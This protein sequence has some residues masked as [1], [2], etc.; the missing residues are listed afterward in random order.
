MKE[1]N[2]RVENLRKI[3]KQKGFD[4]YYVSG[5]DPHQSEYVAPRWRTRHFISGFSGSA[6]TVLVTND[7]A[8]LWT[9]SRYFIQA[10]NEIKDTCF[11]MLRQDTEDPDMISWIKSNLKKDAKIAVEASEISIASFDELNSKLEGSASFVP[12]EGFLDEIWTDRP[13]VPETSV[14][15]MKLEYAGKTSEDKIASVRKSL[16]EKGCFWTFIASLDDIAWITNLR[17]D[18][19]MYNPVF[20]SYMF[21]SMDRAILF[22]S[23]KRFEG[24]DTSSLPFEIM[25]YADAGNLLSSLAEKKGYYNPER[26]VMSFERAAK[27]NPCSSGPDITTLM[28]AKKNALEME[29]MRRAHFEDAVAF[30]NFLAKLD[31]MKKT[32]E[33]EI[34]EKLENER[35]R[36]PL[37]L[38]PSFST[39]AGFKENGAMCHYRAMKDNYKTIEGN[40]LLVLDSGGQYECGT[41]DITRTLLFGQAEENEKRDYT[42][43]LKGHLALAFQRF[44]KGTRGVQLDILAKQFLWQSGQTFYHGTGHGV[45]CRLNVHEGPMRISSALIDVPLEEG[46]VI[47]DEPGLYK[48][49]RY[50]IR[51]ENLIAVKDDVETEFGKFLSF[52]VLTMVPYE[53]RLID[54]RYLSDVEINAINSYHEWV[55]ETLKDHVDESSVPYLESATSPIVRK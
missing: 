36:R 45:G 38:G 12:V 11:K 39:I 7:D 48:E 20:Y 55:Y 37:Y 42:L 34:E 32:D 21:I 14:T 40:G 50:G 29:G 43:V 28:K 5:S 33:L 10:A 9:D 30:V 16:E 19:I 13:D 52:E 3:L 31:P 35:K 23:K 17:A 26:I 8:V 6:G 2:Q 15:Q 25:D 18:D 24:F 27:K 22:T 54:T 47:S 51:I 1:I 41:T 49:G 46:M 4:A 44:Y 53:K